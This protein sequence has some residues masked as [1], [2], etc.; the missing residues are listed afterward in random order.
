MKEREFKRLRSA[1]EDEFQRKMDALNLVYKMSNEDSPKQEKD[2]ASKGALAE[3]VGKAVSQMSSN[4][5]VRQIEN[6]IKVFNPVL[7]A[8]IKR[9]SISNTLKRME[10]TELDVVERGKGKR[11]TIYR[12]RVM[13]R[14]G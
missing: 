2:P 4:F 12:R 14:A 9:S 1:I 3:A 6:A 5:N 11:A 7:A 8:N 10:G 13:T